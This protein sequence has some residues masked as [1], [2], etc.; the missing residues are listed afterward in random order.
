MPNGD[1][2]GTSQAAEP[3]ASPTPTPTPTPTQAQEIER[4]DVAG[5]KER[6]K[7]RF[8][9]SPHAIAGAFHDAKPGDTF[10]EDEVQMR[11]K[12]LTEPLS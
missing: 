11:L 9:V 8:K 5:W 7:R 3:P 2:A 10:T 6:A 1:K 4:Y 12:F